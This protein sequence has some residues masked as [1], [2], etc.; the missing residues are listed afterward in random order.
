MLPPFPSGLPKNIAKSAD[1]HIF[2]GMGNRDFTR[3]HGML[4]LMMV[5]FDVMKNPPILF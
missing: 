5:S 2:S 3:L 1:R 4:E